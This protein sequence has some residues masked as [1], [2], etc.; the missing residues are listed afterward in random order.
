MPVK[1]PL[2][3]PAASL[4]CAHSETG[5]ALRWP[6][7]E[8]CHSCLQA[9]DDGTLP[10]QK[11]MKRQSKGCCKGCAKKGLPR[12]RWKCCATCLAAFDAGRKDAADVRKQ[13]KG[14]LCTRCANDATGRA[15]KAA[16][17]A[18]AAKKAKAA[19]HARQRAARA[20]LPGLRWKPSRCCTACLAK[21]K[22]GTL[23]AKQ[24][25]Q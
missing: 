13:Q 24:V 2:A 5:Q 7:S 20:E 4:T 10:A 21:C 14:K 25:Q 19:A 3:T 9:F 22:A 12:P 17:G 6:R 23:E 8:C 18:A 1:R 11:V 16:S 15:T